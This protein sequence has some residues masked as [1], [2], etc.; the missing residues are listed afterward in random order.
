[1]F[2]SRYNHSDAPDA[3]KMNSECFSK[4]SKK[5]HRKQHNIPHA[6]CN[7]QNQDGEERRRNPNRMKNG[8]SAYYIKP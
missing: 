8:K 4:R 2:S 6:A 7:I 5:L 3:Q 1:M